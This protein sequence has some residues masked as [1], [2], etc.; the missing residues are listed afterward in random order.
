MPR[1][2]RGVNAL[3]KRNKTL[4]LA[5]G[6]RGA[7]HK[8]IKSAREA[9][10]HSMA[11]AYRDRRNRKREF[12]RLW[13]VRINAAAR[14]EGL[15]YNRFMEGLKKAGIE[16]NRK[17]LA[18]LAVADTKAFAHFAELAKANLAKKTGAEKVNA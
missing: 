1:V 15:S 6:Y 7:R 11:Y 18:D 16:I 3:K 14:I 12:R 5:K 10:I 13:I 4:K 8:R 9:V 2:K 17:M